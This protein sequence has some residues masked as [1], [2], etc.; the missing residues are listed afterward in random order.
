MATAKERHYWAHLRAAL[1][2]GQWTAAYP[3]KAPNG[4]ALSWPE[5]IRKFNKHCKGFTHIA[6]VAA[7]NQV[8]ASLLST[9][10][11]DED[12]HG[13]TLRPPLDLGDECLVPQSRVEA[14][15]VGYEALRNLEPSNV[16][17]ISTVHDPARLIMYYSSRQISRLRITPTL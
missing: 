9:G 6:E 8:L 2:A 14:A 15:S 17:F 3:A 12:V 5:L 16:R 4:V 1:S 7:Q 10:V 13:N 11:D